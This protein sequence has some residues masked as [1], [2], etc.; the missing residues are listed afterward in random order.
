MNDSPGRGRGL[1]WPW[2]RRTAALAAMALIAL[3]ATACAGGPSHD[4]ATGGPTR[5]QAALAYARCMRSHGVP[6][7]PDPDSNGDFHLSNNQ[8]GRGSKGS[9]SSSVSSQE[10]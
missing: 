1:R 4:S 5:E 9:E 7:F 3:L 6:G 8:Q 10:M 2:L